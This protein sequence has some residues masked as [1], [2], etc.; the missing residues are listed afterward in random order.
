MSYI[1]PRYFHM[2]GLYAQD[3]NE[4][5]NQTILT[6]LDRLMDSSEGK[7]GDSIGLCYV[8]AL[9]ATRWKRINSWVL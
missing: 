6:P 8:L 3:I 2:K 7:L 9:E 1:K 4:S 5:F